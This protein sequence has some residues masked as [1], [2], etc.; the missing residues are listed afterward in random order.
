MVIGHGDHDFDLTSL[1]RKGQ[2]RAA[3]VL[4]VNE[5]SL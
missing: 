3:D 2:P 5:F 1:L 4:S